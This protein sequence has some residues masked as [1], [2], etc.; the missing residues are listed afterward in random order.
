MDFV[1]LLHTLGS[2]FRHYNYACSADKST[3]FLLSAYSRLPWNIFS[4]LG[5]FEF[6]RF[7]L[8]A[9]MAN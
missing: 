8:D 6:G 9:C 2:S 3:L 4:V 5:S 1:L 7:Y